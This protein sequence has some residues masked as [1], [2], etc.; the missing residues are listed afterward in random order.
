MKKLTNILILSVLFLVTAC[1]DKDVISSKG[2]VVLPGVTNLALQQV[3]QHSIKLTWNLPGSIP[4]TIKQP[5]KV[6]IEVREIVS[7]T[8]SVVVF[9]TMLDNAPSEYVYTLPVNTK[10]YH[11]T[12]K[13]NGST[14]E[15]DPYYSANI[16]SLGQTVV[17]S[18]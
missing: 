2:G 6:Y 1:T 13:L 18:K 8:S 11:F 5:L 4:P 7:I 16:Y 10:T 15:S 12:V 17:Y 14:V 3:N 9:T